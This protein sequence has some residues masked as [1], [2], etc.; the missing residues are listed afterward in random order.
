M[1]ETPNRREFLS[2][3]LAGTTAAA[4]SLYDKTNLLFGGIPEEERDKGTL[5]MVGGGMSNRQH[6]MLPLDET[7]ARAIYDEH[8]IMQR[9]VREANA[10]GKEVV[11]VTSGSEEDA[12]SNAVEYE[13]ELRRLGVSHVHTILNRA[14]AND[15]KLA[16]KIFK[17]DANGKI[18]GEIPLVFLSGGDQTK[19][20]KEFKIPRYTMR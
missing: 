11:V 7:A 19:L 1:V 4:I 12:F 9:I 5:I 10:E 13:E 18:S 16:E 20:V 14:G 6:R 2:K 17:R 8:G 3:L 15:K